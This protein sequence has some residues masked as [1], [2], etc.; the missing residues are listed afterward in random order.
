MLTTTVSVIKE[1]RAERKTGCFSLDSLGEGITE[2]GRTGRTSSQGNT[3]AAYLS[4]KSLTLVLWLCWSSLEWIVYKSRFCVILQKL[5]VGT[6]FII[7]LVLLWQST[8]TSR[9]KTFS[10]EIWD[11]Y[12]WPQTKFCV[13]QFSF[14]VMSNSSCEFCWTAA[15]PASSIINPDIQLHVHWVS[16]HIQPPSSVWSTSVP[17]FSIFPGSAGLFKWAA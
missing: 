4:R 9:E 2:E 15:H 16:R 6:A 14:P 1:T 7:F 10:L 17:A 12:K 11:R 8:R 5:A 13:V 3:V